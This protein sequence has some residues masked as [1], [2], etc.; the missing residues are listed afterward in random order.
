MGILHWRTVQR[1]GGNCEDSSL[2]AEE[3]KE[4]KYK[5]RFKGAKQ[6]KVS[7]LIMRDTLSGCKYLRD[8]NICNDKL[9]GIAYGE[10]MNMKPNKLDEEIN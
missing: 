6:M 2:Y 10:W 7:Y 9:F 1:N 3:Q 5:D 4:L 8:R